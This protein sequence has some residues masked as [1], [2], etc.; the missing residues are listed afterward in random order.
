MKLADAQRWMPAVSAAL[1]LT[2]L[3]L[4][5]GFRLMGL[6]FD[7]GTLQHPDE[8]FLLMLISQVAWPPSLGVYFDSASSPL[9][10]FNIP[11]VTFYVYGNLPVFLGKAFTDLSIPLGHFGLAFPG[12]VLATL[13]DVAVLL[14]VFFLTRKLFTDRA[15]WLA[16]SLYGFMVLPIQ[17]S[18][19]FAVDPFLCLFLT[20]ALGRAVDVVRDTKLK[21]AAAMGGWWGCALASKLSA[22]SFTAVILT[23]GWVIFRRRGWRSGMSIVLAA[24]ASAALVFRILNPYAFSGIVSLDPRFLEAFRIL[25]ETH[26]VEA[27]FPPSFQWID[28]T[29]L[30]YP[31]QNLALFGVGLPLF[32][33]AT[34]GMVMTL[35]RCRKHV[36]D[37]LVV[38]LVWLVSVFA[39]VS[40]LH[41]QSMRYLLP[42]YPVL[43][44]LAAHALDTSLRVRVALPWR[45]MPVIAVVGASLL[46]AYA[47][48][49]IYRSPMTRVSASKWIHEHVPPGSVIGVEH[50]DDALPLRL[51][52]FDAEKFKR[53]ELEPVAPETPEKRERLLQQLA[54]VEYLIIASERGYASVA[55]LPD[56]FPVAIRYYEMLFDGSAGFRLVA[57]ISSYPRLGGLII[58]DDLAEE[59]FKV[60]DH[61]RVLIYQKSPT[62]SLEKVARELRALELPQPAWNPHGGG[63]IRELIPGR[64]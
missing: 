51:P 64:L 38:V 31:L 18:N 13:T 17:L 25:G 33:A 10:P 4:S 44:I 53:L 14:S 57:D 7:A 27:W 45:A 58:R 22:L 49:S 56:S 43:A 32:V 54:S 34:V 62:F 48:S 39:S 40:V 46:W 37:A 16:A 8:R 52:G 29:P 63:V 30:I 6:D 9:N 41:V 55:R 60:Y 24:L 2:M 61:P 11:G 20:L 50:W 5:L 19:F 42:A 59:A 12:R 28:R 1:A 36:D 23:A 35:S 3:G 15:A 26:K 47:F 21:T